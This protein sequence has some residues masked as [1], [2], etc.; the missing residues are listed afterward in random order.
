LE[1]GELFFSKHW[2]KFPN[3]GNEA[4]LCDA[5]ICSALLS[6]LPLCEGLL[7]ETGFT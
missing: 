1:K 3:A 4:R 5:D 2:K 6:L 7:V